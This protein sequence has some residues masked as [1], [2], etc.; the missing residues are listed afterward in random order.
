MLAGLIGDC[1][2]AGSA[3]YDAAAVGA[4]VHGAAGLLAARS[5]PVAAGDLVAAL[6]LAWQ[7]I[8]E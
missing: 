5:G 8:R 3:P 7:N 1:S 4:Y 6:P 2:R